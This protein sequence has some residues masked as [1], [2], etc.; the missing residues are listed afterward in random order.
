MGE[1]LVWGT[2]WDGRSTAGECMRDT[3][4]HGCTSRYYGGCWTALQCIAG[5]SQNRDNMIVFNSPSL[6]KP[7]MVCQSNSPL[8]QLPL[9]DLSLQ[10]PSV[11]SKRIDFTSVLPEVEILGLAPE[12]Q[13]LLNTGLSDA[14]VTSIQSS[15][16]MSTRS[17]YCSKWHAFEHWCA[18]I[19]EPPMH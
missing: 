12:R 9:G 4:V 1:A 10:R 19:G 7:S 18:L 2:P 17:L 14:V 8:G 16:A 13:Y 3:S 15:R 11:A 6:R 5:Q